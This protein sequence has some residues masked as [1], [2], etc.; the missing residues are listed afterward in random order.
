[1]NDQEKHFIHGNVI[2]KVDRSQK[3]LI[4]RFAKHDVAKVA[5][6]MAGHGVMN[7]EIK[8]LCP[9]M[10]LAG[11]A[12]TVLTRPGDALF[13][14]K[15]IDLTQPGDVIVIDASGFK[16]VSVIGE[17]LAYFFKLK[18][19]FLQSKAVQTP[20][21]PI[22]FAANA[23]QTVK[24]T[25]RIADGW[26]PGALDP[27]TY[28]KYLG[29]I[30]KSAEK[31]GRNPDDIEPAIVVQIGI[32]QDADAAKKS[33][34][35]ETKFMIV[36]SGTKYLEEVVKIEVPE[37]I[38]DILDRRFGLLTLP[39]LDRIYNR[40]KDVMDAVPDEF[41]E[42]TSI[43]GAPEDVIERLDRL[44]KVGCRTFMTNL[45]GRDHDEAFRLFTKKVM[46][47][48]MEKSR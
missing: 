13:V 14:Q 7:Y 3:E 12:L 24:L 16:D 6:A 41:A 22:W 18:E 32:S 46:P 35:E 44:V 43:S 1:M 48:F 42:K 37:D 36:W 47:Y 4:R 10:R 8:P 29:E 39:V 15:A 34:L 30:G 40:F 38:R 27:A 33:V 23:P 31:A 5:D 9:E 20:G 25:G 28:A 21:P 17:R 26:L 11:S 45:Y 2:Q 19:A